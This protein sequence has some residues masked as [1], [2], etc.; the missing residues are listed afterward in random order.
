MFRQVCYPSD[1]LVPPVEQK[2]ENKAEIVENE[3]NTY[4]NQNSSI[5]KV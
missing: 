5:P 1:D 3:T 4:S 2:S